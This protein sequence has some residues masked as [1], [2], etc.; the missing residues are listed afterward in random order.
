MVVETLMMQQDV[1][2]IQ[3]KG[4]KQVIKYVL[5]YSIF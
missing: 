3:L 1:Y 5:K 2:D 4:E